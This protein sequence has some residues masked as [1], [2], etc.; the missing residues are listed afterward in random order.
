MSQ[1]S[2][3]PSANVDASNRDEVLS[4]DALLSCLMD[5]ELG[6]GQ[7]E[8]TLQRL[9][10]DARLQR[11]WALMHAV[12]DAL[13]SREL[14]Q[15]HRLEFHERVVQRLAQ[16]PSIAAPRWARER[17]LHRWAVPGLALASAVA[18]LSVVVLQ[19]REVPLTA[20]VLQAEVSPSRVHGPAHELPV[21]PYLQAHREF[22]PTG[23]VL[24]ASAPYLRT[25]A[26]AQP[27]E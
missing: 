25:S 11:D 9:T 24:P 12:G 8:R 1:T 10:Q 3:V 15:V 2:P 22:V 5:G 21:H 18:V 27:Q 14:V 19:M 7:C 23:G 17:A 6:E 26:A 16:E 13:R 20:P 4:D